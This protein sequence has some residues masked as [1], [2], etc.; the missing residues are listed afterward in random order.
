MQR[1]ITKQRTAWRA[2]IRA[3]ALAGAA[4]VLTVVVLACGPNQA[5]AHYCDSCLDAGAAGGGDAGD[6]HEGE[7]YNPECDCY[8]IQGMH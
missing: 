4:T 2:P 7:T 8:Y 5:V 1:N 3:V 6:N